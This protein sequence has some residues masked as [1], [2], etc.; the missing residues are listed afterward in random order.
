MGDNV[1]YLPIC[2]VCKCPMRLVRSLGS[3]D[4]PPIT[5]VFECMNCHRELI[6]VFADNIN[7][8]FA[9]PTILLARHGWRKLMPRPFHPRRDLAALAWQKSSKTAMVL[10][11]RAAAS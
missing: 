10:M 4:R 6:R 2:A 3:E 1:V 8:A 5:R 11:M 7:D 9:L